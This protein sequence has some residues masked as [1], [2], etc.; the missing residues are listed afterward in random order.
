MD[1]PAE[2]RCDASD[3]RLLQLSRDG[4]R[5]AFSELWRR[6]APV[7]LAYARS[8]GGS[9]PDPE[10]LVSEAFISIL[11]MLRTG[12]G[13]EERLRPY[14]LTTIKNLRLSALRRM[15]A[16][17][18][19]DEI[20]HPPSTVGAIDVD[21]IVDSEAI[22]EAFRSLPERWQHAL[23]LSE[24]E[25][26]PPRVIA[27]ALA[28]RPN[29]AAALTYRARAALRKAWIR[30]QL[31]CAPAGTEHAEVIELLG[32]YAYEELSP[33]AH[34]LVT[35]HLETCSTCR[36][37]AEEA[38]HLAQAIMLGPLLAGVGSLVIASTLLS[39]D[40]VAAAPPIDGVSPSVAP[41]VLEA[42]GHAA[43]L[44]WPVAAT[45]AAALSIGGSLLLRL[46]PETEPLAPP[47]AAVP[48]APV[49]PPPEWPPLAPSPSPSAPILRLPAL[50]AGPV[51]SPSPSTPST[52]S[53]APRPTPTPTPPQPTQPPQPTP[54]PGPG[55]PRPVE[56]PPAGE[57]ETR[58]RAP[59]APA[60]ASPRGTR[61]VRRCGSMSC[62]TGATIPRTGTAPRPPRR[63]WWR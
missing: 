53:A 42:T 31:R 12:G 13:P 32:A 18:S 8:L 40:I 59:T 38:R 37:A 45:V 9:P 61:G 58:P 29:S 2:E 22:A 50:P 43:S 14:L 10:D 47:T 24:V 11:R 3:A 57:D 63:H 25:Q 1:D 44:L 6:H 54:G 15:P 28:I 17:V 26:L 7:A 34:R 27:E 51:T 39:S 49:T 35:H 33:R 19:I 16:T 20:E 30:A 5:R 52:P 62:P 41:Q 55:Q 21:A 56:L 60:E 23:W 4:D 46:P 48:T 36:D